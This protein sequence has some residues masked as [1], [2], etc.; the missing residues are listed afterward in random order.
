MFFSP[1]DDTS[2]QT[3]YHSYWYSSWA[4]SYDVGG[5]LIRTA[6]GIIQ[7]ETGDLFD[8]DKLFSSSSSAGIP[9][10]QPPPPPGLIRRL[11]QRFL[12][13]LP[14][15]GVGS[16]VHMLSWTMLTPVHWLA[17]FRGSRNRRGSGSRDTAAIIL[18]L[19]IIAG[20][21]RALYKVYQFTE[22]VT[23]RILLRAEEM[24]LEVD[25]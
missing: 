25:S 16:L 23:K 5:D 12:L 21:A 17:R 22:S 20:A 10:R 6:L 15:V 8:A 1:T 14:V 18:V 9:F 13:G 24:I 11:F 7:D 4:Y 2:A 3:G 19:L